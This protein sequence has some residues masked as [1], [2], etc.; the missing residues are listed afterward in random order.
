M[1]QMTTNYVNPLTGSF[2]QVNGLY[3]RMFV[4][5]GGV[6]PTENRQY[7]MFHEFSTPS[8]G[9]EVVKVVITGNTVMNAFSVKVMSGKARV[10]IVAG[11]TEGG[12][13]SQSISKLPVNNM[14]TAVP[15]TSTTTVTSGGTL[16]GGTTL[17]LFLVNT[18]DNVNQSSGVTS[19]EDFAIGFAAGTY[20]IRITNTDNST[21][22]GLVK[23]LWTEL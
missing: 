13:Y 12:T 8:A 17:D 16:T 20:Y 14:T 18:G 3:G 22:A 9:T 4:E 5:T 21:T 19:G 23:A 10:E 2:E 11:G 6:S 1:S 7:F 15:R